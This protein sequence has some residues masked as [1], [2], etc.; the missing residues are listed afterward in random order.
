M[1]LGNQIDTLYALKQTKAEL[2]RKERTIGE[3][4]REHET[5]L[6]EELKNLGISKASGEKAT[7]R[8]SSLNTPSVKDWDA[9]YEYIREN[10]A[11]YLLQRSV[12]G[13]PYRELIDAGVEVPGVETFS[14]TSISTTKV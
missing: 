3:Q 1:T 5:K 8:V 7:I 12:N 10:D 13:A 4:I 6:Q 2:A 9:L 14:K 11:F